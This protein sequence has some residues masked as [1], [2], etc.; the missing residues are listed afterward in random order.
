MVNAKEICSYLRSGNSCYWINTKEPRRAMKYLQ[1]LITSIERK[2]GGKY[3]VGAWSCLTDSKPASPL[4]KLDDAK[5]LTVVFLQNYHWFIDKPVIIQKIQ[6]SVEVWKNTGKAIIVIAPLVKIPLELKEDFVTMEFTL[7]D[8]AEVNESIDFITKSAQKSNGR[9]FKDPTS[10]ERKEIVESSKGL[11]QQEIENVLSRSLALRKR[12]DLSLINDERAAIV[13][14]SGFI[15]VFKPTIT[16]KD[17]KGYGVVKHFGL[18]MV[19]HPLSKGMLLMGPPGCGKT[20]F[21]EALVGET[22]MLGLNFDFGKLTSKFQGELDTNID[23]VINL[24][25][26][27]GNCIVMI[28]EFEKQFSGAGADGSTDGG[29]IVRGTG[30]WLRFMQDRPKGVY[31]IGTCNSFKGIPPAYLRPG[32]W[33]CAPIFI[34]LPN[35]EEKRDIL[36]Y[37]LGEYD[38]DSV[39]DAPEMDEW[40]GAEIE[41][42]ARNAH[43]MGVSMVDAAKY[44]IPLAKTMGDE[45]SALRKWS[46]GRTVPASEV[47]NVDDGFRMLDS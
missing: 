5:A 47:I 26:A 40:T 20:R 42:C 27:V 35:D 29:T 18:S 14:S 25:K 19:K 6:D 7:P 8:E 13:E 39:Q 32:R 12:F 43:I 46:V 15:D 45:I 4:L 23:N 30:R 9:N 21:L 16:F 24:I 2:D 37:Y 31:I 34:D 36:D 38:L 1:K 44:I 22:K 41:A 17:L 3:L 11:T 10:A 28:D 33:D